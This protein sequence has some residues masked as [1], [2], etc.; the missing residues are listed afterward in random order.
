MMRLH[1][2]RMVLILILILGMGAGKAAAQE[3]T[4]FIIPD[5]SGLIQSVKEKGRSSE[6]GALILRSQKQLT[7]EKNGT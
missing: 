5:A 1:L 7:V 3:N 2:Y 4:L 6:T